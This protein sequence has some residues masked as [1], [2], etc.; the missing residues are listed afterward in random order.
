MGRK[1]QALKTILSLMIK[2]GLLHRVRSASFS[3]PIFLIDKKNPASLPRLL[4][5]VRNLN[6]H[7]M[8]IQQ[9]VPKIQSLLEDIGQYQPS[10]FSNMDLASAFFSLKPDPKAQ[11][12]LTLSSQF[13]LFEAKMAV[14]GL[15]VIPTIFSDFIHRALH[16]DTNGDIDPVAFLVGYLDDVITF[17]PKSTLGCEPHKELLKQI[18]KHI[19]PEEIATFEKMTPTE[20]SMACD[21][22]V[23]NNLVFSRLQ[24]HNF[25][26]K[27]S[28]LKLFL[29][30][31]STLGVILT[32]EGI[33]VDPLRTDKIIKTPFPTTR[34]QMMSYCGFLSSIG[35]YS[36]CHLSQQHGI[37]SELT[38]VTKEYEPLSK[39]Q[40]AFEE[41]KRLLT[42]EP[43]FLNYPNQNNPKI[44]FV[45]SS[46]ILLGAVLFDAEFPEISVRENVTEYDK[47]NMIRRDSH[48]QKSLDKLKIPAF[49]TPIPSKPGSSFFECLS[50]FIELFQI[51]NFPVTHKLIRQYLLH[52]LQ[53]S[54]L[55]HTFA[56][57]LPQSMTWAQF[58]DKFYPS[59]S[60]ID[61]QGI[62]LHVSAQLLER[63][64]CIVTNYSIQTISGGSKASA[65]PRI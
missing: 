14:Q 4:A 26:I 47:T 39:H 60:G 55:K 21:H 19:L 53:N 15:S 40:E 37:L 1:R 49:P 51:K 34:K 42:S 41:S 3:S 52:Q 54:M 10:L 62:L 12:L 9:I 27:I 17:S 50:H 20:L 22:Y 31:T 64:I 59:N 45:D 30:D 36:S 46:D 32:S 38:S 11:K 23:L 61:P 24:F 13:G 58:F 35:L 65:K 44:L 56:A 29:P 8:P 28:K 48:I 5:D 63:H 6:E 43:L 57:S 33:K 16:T 25:C 2:E 7:L 18:R